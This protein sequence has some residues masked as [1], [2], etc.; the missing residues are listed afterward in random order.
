[1]KVQWYMWVVLALILAPIVQQWIVTYYPAAS[2]PV[3]GLVVVLI[4][5]VAKWLE[6][7][8]DDN[9]AK[10]A[11][12]MLPPGAAATPV[13]AAQPSKAKRLFWDA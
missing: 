6:L 7:V 12:A 5:G 11:T 4:G 2:Y 3:A 1:M 9:K 13:A 8:L 10:K